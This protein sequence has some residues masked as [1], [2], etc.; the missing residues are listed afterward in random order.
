VRLDDAAVQLLSTRFAA[1][2][3]AAVEQ[4]QVKPDKIIMLSYDVDEGIVDTL[5]GVWR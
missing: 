3:P 2:L 1:S 5:A 4:F